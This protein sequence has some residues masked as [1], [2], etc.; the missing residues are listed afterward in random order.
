MDPNKRKLSTAGDSLYKTLE[1]EKGASA[2]EIRKAYRKLALR[3]HSDKNPGNPEAAEK[4]KEINHANSILNDENKRQI[5]DQYG[6]MGLLAA[7]EFGEEGVKFHFL[8]LKCWFKTLVIC[9]L[10]FTCW[11]C[12][13][14]C[15]KCG[16][17]K[18]KEFKYVGPEQLEAQMYEEQDISNETVIVGQPVSSPA[19]GDSAQHT[20]IIAMPAPNPDTMN[21]GAGGDAASTIQPAASESFA[22][23]QQ[24]S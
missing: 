3:Y 15:G 22:F 16:S 20:V 23:V 12:C 18:Q 1:L 11:C 13:F 19:P 6:S 10:F 9:C 24:I 21:T 5:Y 17:K 2:E 4:F 8:M 7:E 14:C